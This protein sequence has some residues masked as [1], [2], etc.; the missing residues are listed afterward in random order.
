MDEM[1]TVTS[2]PP[3]GDRPGGGP[4]RVRKIAGEALGAPFTQ[5][6]WAELAYCLAGVRSAPP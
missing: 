6:A 3:S 1:A 4:L 2:S 5:R